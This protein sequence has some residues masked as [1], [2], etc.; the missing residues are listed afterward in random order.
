MFPQSDKSCAA[1]PQIRLCDPVE[2]SVEERA[3]LLRVAHDSIHATLEER[4]IPVDPPC[5]HLGERRGVFTTLYLHG[6]LRG[7]VGYV[8]PVIPLY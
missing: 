5:P 6:E 1:V 4:Q 7:C 3:L 2:F 8:F